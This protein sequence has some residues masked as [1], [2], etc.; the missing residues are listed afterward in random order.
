LLQVANYKLTRL[1]DRA[2]LKS[3]V[4]FDMDTL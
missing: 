3:G 4:S 2:P 1:D